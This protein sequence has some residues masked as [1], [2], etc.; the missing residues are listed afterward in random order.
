MSAYIE[1]KYPSEPIQSHW[2]PHSV[3]FEYLST[4]PHRYSQWSEPRNMASKSRLIIVDSRWN[5][6]KKLDDQ[7]FDAVLKTECLVD[8]RVGE[9]TLYRCGR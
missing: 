7:A 6:W 8:L 1:I 5:S 2:W 9:Y 4:L 3:A